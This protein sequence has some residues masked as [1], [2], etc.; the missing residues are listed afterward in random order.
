MTHLLA[1][2]KAILRIAEE[3]GINARLEQLPLHTSADEVRALLPHLNHDQAI[4]GVLVQMPPPAHL[5]QTMEG[6]TIACSK[7]ID[8]ISPYSF[9]DLFLGCMVSAFDGSDVNA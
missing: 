5:S 3:V 6:E 2:S 8:G 4:H 9:W 7:D 1:F